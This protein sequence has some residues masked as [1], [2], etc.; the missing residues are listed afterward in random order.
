M[1]VICTVVADGAE[2]AFAANSKSVYRS[3][4]I[5]VTEKL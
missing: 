4:P 1:R 3:Y 5:N 2:V